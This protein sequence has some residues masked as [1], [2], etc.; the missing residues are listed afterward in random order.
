LN[1]DLH[2]KA[3]NLKAKLAT[4]KELSNNKKTLTNIQEWDDFILAM[5]KEMKKKIINQS[6]RTANFLTESHLEMFN[7]QL[8]NIA[9][10]NKPLSNKHTAQQQSTLTLARCLPPINSS[11]GTCLKNKTT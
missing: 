7:N 5:K 9:E 3:A 4:P 6:T 2:P 8:V 1:E 11:Q 10:T